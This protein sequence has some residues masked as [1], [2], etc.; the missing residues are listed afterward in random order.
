MY[1]YSFQNPLRIRLPCHVT[2]ENKFVADRAL[3]S[4]VRADPEAAA[5]T[6]VPQKLSAAMSSVTLAG[7]M[8]ENSANAGPS[9]EFSPRSKYEDTRHAA[10]RLQLEMDRPIIQCAIRKPA[11]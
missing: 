7:E 5:I 8:P 2:V 4:D 3:P 11:K 1:R 6:T 9:S 10:L